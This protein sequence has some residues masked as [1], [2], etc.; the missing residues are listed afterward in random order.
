MQEGGRAGAHDL[1]LR[2]VYSPRVLSPASRHQ[3]PPPGYPQ[4]AETSCAQARPAAPG[5]S[6]GRDTAVGCL[7]QSLPCLVGGVAVGDTA[8][9]RSL[10]VVDCRPAEGVVGVDRSRCREG[11]RSIAVQ[12]LSGHP[13]RIVARVEQGEREYGLPPYMFDLRESLQRARKAQFALERAQLRAA[14]RPSAVRT[15]STVSSP[16]RCTLLSRFDSHLQAIILKP[17]TATPLHSPHPSTPPHSPAHAAPT[18]PACATA[19]R[20]P[21]AG[22]P[23][24]AGSSSSDCRPNH[25]QL[26]IHMRV[27]ERGELTIPSPRR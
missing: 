6:Q 25:D 4:T 2:R 20:P 14:P 11:V 21:P 17:L 19:T 27:P 16:V 10:P 15:P 8:V 23:P 7:S 13:V 3:L 1:P 5:S 18:L 9:N 22:S 26:S 12:V 24:A